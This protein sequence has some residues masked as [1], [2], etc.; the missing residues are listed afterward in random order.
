[1]TDHAGPSKLFTVL[2]AHGKRASKYFLRHLRAFIKPSPWTT[3]CGRACKA[4]Y[5]VKSPQR[6]VS[7]SHAHMLLCLQPTPPIICRPYCHAFAQI[8]LKLDRQ[9]DQILHH[10]T[11]LTPWSQCST[12]LALHSSGVAFHASSLTSQSATCRTCRVNGWMLTWQ[13]WE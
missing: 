5:H 12:E 10:V 2:L 13:R 8:Q 6:P 1:M 3:A 11:H 9:H 4:C 7:S